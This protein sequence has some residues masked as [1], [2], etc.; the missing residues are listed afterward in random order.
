MC[1][2]NNFEEVFIRVLLVLSTVDLQARFSL[3]P[4]FALTG[5]QP[6]SKCY[7]NSIRIPAKKGGSVPF[8]E[9]TKELKSKSQSDFIEDAIQSME[10]KK[11][12]RMNIANDLE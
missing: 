3:L 1:P 5:H 10:T 8:F 6:R 4:I 11:V 9:Y 12:V 2:N 7:Q